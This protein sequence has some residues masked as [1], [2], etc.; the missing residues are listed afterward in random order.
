MAYIIN[1]TNGS[2]VATVEDGAI[3]NTTDLTLVGRNFAGYGEIQNENFLKLLENFSN[4]QAPSNPIEGQLWYDSV[5]NQINVYNSASWK[6]IG[7]LEVT[8]ADPNETKTYQS[9]DL[10]YNPESQQL[11]AH[12]GTSFELIGPPNAADLIASWR[13]DY[14][15]DAIIGNNVPKYN[16]KA[17][18]GTEESIIAV[19]SNETYITQKT[20]INNLFP[21]AESNSP[22]NFKIVKGVTL[23]GADPTTGIS[24]NKGIYFWG[25]AAH[26]I[27]SDRATVADSTAGF[28]FTATNTNANYNL[29]FISTASAT[30]ASI[31]YI[32]TGLFY[33]P[34][35][36]VL[37]VIATA[38]RY[39]DLAERYH[40][41]AVYSEGTV[42]VIGGR[43][44]VTISSIDADVSVAGIVSVRPAYRMNEDAG[45][46]STHPFIALKGRVP[47]KVHGWIHKGDLL[48]TGRVQGHGRAYEKGDNPNAV[49]AKALES[50]SSDGHGIIEV[51]VV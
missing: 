39:S 22:D 2:I 27:L 7:H 29:P 21:T 25:S 9:G 50:H 36:N 10:W 37:N 6:P 8:T 18:V 49:F 41:D 35:T 4:S 20:N 40:A 51:M 15:Y 16:I 3:D 32:S 44:E 43:N 11:F 48:V 28:Q 47:C 24:S 38:A 34:S 17:V 14:E 33:N 5:G 30:S 19:V 42:L 12:N 46:Q 45:D 26:S 31:A 23:V 13:G 1:K